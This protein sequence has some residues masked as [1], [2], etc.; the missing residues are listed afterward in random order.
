MGVLAKHTI[1]GKLAVVSEGL[2]KVDENLVLATEE[3]ALEAKNLEHIRVFGHTNTK[4]R[5]TTPSASW[6]RARLVK[7]AQ[8]KKIEVDD[9]ITKAELLKA[10]QEGK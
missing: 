6:T 3:E 1:T 2:L 8:H 4:D 9:S 7:Y 10:L 5:D